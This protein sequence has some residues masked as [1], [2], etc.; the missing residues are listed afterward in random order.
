MDNLIFRL[1]ALGLFFALIIGVGITW[2]Q[3]HVFGQPDEDAVVTSVVATGKIRGSGKSECDEA[4]YRLRIDNPRPDIA[5]RDAYFLECTEE[6]EVGDETTI[7]RVPGQPSRTYSDPIPFPSIPIFM[8]G[9]VVAIMILGFLGTA[10]M[11]LW[12]RITD[13]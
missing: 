8:V 13:R 2:D 5:E 4:L 1:A 3:R 12:Y 10:I 7:R 9:V 6:Y 11:T